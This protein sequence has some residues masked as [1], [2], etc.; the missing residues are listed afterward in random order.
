MTGANRGTG[1]AIAA[2]LAE[3]GMQVW[4]LNRNPSGSPTEIICDLSEPAELSAAITEVLQR[5]DRL[6]A[7]VT[8]AV[9]RYFAP[10]ADIDMQRWN[11]A[12]TVNLTSIVATVQQTLPLL[13]RSQGSIVLMG[14]HAGTRFFES[15]LSYCATKA[16]LKALCE[17]LLLEERPYGVR[18]SLVSPGAIANEDGDRSPMKMSTVSVAKVVRDLVL[19][20]SDVAVGEIELRPASLGPPVV[21]GLDRLQSV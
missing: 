8:N 4:E 1:R 11:A 14:S 16:A 10:V 6:D 21:A 9:D 5:V 20:P 18:T 12:L 17:V 7:L 15:G 2:E 3:A 19:N 13:R